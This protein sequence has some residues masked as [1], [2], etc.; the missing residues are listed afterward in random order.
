MNVAI[1]GAGVVGCALAHELSSNSKLSVFILEKNK[2]MGE[3]VTSRNSGVIHS[4][5]YYKPNSLKAKLCIE[6]QGLLYEWC[7][8]KGIPHRKIGKLIVAHKNENDLLENLASNALASGVHKDNLKILKKEYLQK[9]YPRIQGDSAL[10]VSQSGIV[11]AHELCRSF[12]VSATQKG[13]EFIFLCEV[14]GIDY[15]GA[16]SIQTNRGEI[17]ADI[18]INAAGLYADK[19]A[20]LAGINKYKI[21]PWRGDYFKIKL[22]YKMDK[23]IYPIKKPKDPGLGVHLTLDLQGQYFLGPDIEPAAHISDFSERPEKCKDFFKSAGNIL[24]DIKQ[25]MLKYETCGIR[26]KLRAFNE[27]EE[28]D[29]IVSEDL[30]GFIN[31]VGIESPGLTASPALARYVKKMIQ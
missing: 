18:V 1:V 12:Y 25:D 28:K 20:N 23:L 16:Y 24:K 6:G 4:G 14:Q 19:I 8:K 2:G 9:E 3:G 27:K 5:L 26:P 30:P 13:A 7:Q 17:K 11:N 29:F 15:D 22:P 10:F 21:Y 31:L